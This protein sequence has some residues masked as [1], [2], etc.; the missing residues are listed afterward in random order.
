[1]I[2]ARP[3]TISKRDGWAPSKDFPI[4]NEKTVLRQAGVGDQARRLATCLC[5]VAS[6]K[7]GQKPSKRS[8][9]ALEVDE[10]IELAGRSTTTPQ[11]TA[12]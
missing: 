12:S 3:F 9:A 4:T 8:A 1:M 10:E 7:A 2:E 6:A 11:K 5:E